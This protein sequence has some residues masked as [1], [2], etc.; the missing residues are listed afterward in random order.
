MTGI[1]RRLA[2]DLERQL[3]ELLSLL[4]RLVNID[5]GSY[6]A[7]GVNAV[8]DLVAGEL[9]KLGFTVE[10]TPIAGRGDQMTA[11]RA[12]GGGPRLLILGHADTVWPAGTVAEWPFAR[13]DDRI[14]GPGVGDMKGGVIS[15]VFALKCV[16]ARR[17]QGFGSCTFLLV[18]DE[19]LGSVQS[20]QW[21]EREAGQADI[22]LTLEPCRP[23]GGVVTG[24][25][26]VGAVIVRASG[27][28]AHC[29]AAPEKGASA[30]RA[31][32][33]LVGELEGLSD[34][35]RGVSASVGILR[36]GAAR[37]VVPPDA[38]MHV[39]LRAPD[40]ASAEA[41]LQSVR[42]I[43]GRP[44]FDRRVTLS[45]SGGISRPA[46]PKRAGTEKL[47]AAAQKI[48][49]ELDTPIFEVT[50][51]GGSDGSF[52]AALGVPTLDGLGPICHDSCSRRE[53]VEIASIV[54]R[55]ALLGALMTAAS[56]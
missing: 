31:L 54:P 49:A 36:G 37:Q 34:H 14:T 53:T 23:G 50:S 4:E 6:H 45:M 41:L 5:S 17:V 19:E 8:I 3:P 16:L 24:R 27:L 40:A 13:M 47:Y 10:R 9:M 38:E 46:F 28:S 2:E 48:S 35:A 33:G 55:A 29:A 42:A 44:A 12:L 22:C 43:V 56:D 15:A 20:R 51:R 7:S 26:A 39:D 18:P 32:A 25:G 11:R 21:I 30:V 52:A 1:A